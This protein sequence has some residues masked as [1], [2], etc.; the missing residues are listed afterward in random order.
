MY[1]HEPVLKM[2]INGIK[3][4]MVFVSDKPDP[5]AKDWHDPGRKY[6]EQWKPDHAT[7]CTAGDDLAGIDFRFMR[8]L[9]VSISSPTKNRA[10][11]LFSLAKEAGASVVAACHDIPGNRPS[12]PL[13]WFEIYYKTEIKNG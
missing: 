10:K 11:A 5:I 6:G 9:R 4:S 8:G 1:G 12:D 7:V 2:R 13:G 3:P